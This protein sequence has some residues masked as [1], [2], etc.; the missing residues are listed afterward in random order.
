IKDRYKFIQTY[1]DNE[2]PELYN[3]DDD[4]DELHNLALLP[5]YRDKVKKYHALLVSEL[6][7][8]D[9]RFV[10]KLPAMRGF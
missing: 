4:P 5:E 7:R 8:T 10:N 1:V 6:K 2:I 3:I 9:A